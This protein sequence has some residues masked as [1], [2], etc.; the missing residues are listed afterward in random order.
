MISQIEEVSQKGDL[1]KASVDS[2]FAELKGISLTSMKVQ[3][4][5][6]RNAQ[7][8]KLKDLRDELSRA[9]DSRV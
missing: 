3:E 8:R 5:E 1:I 4:D 6:A 9:F 7:E 2:K